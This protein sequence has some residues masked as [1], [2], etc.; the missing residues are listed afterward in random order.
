MYS[1]LLPLCCCD[2]SAAAMDRPLDWHR[3][4]ASA[5]ARVRSP[6]TGLLRVN[7]MALRRPHARGPQTHRWSLV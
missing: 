1:M 7:A 2:P 6:A 4:H 5:S 3:R